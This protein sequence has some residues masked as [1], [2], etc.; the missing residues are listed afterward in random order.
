MD[1]IPVANINNG[2]IWFIVYYSK[3]ETKGIVYGD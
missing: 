2:F 3:R 1:A